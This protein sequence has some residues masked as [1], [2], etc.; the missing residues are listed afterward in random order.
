MALIDK[1]S[2]L[3]VPS[4]VAEGKAFNILPSGNR[5]PDNKG[6]AGYDQ[7]RADFDFDR[8]SNT[9][10]TRVNADGLIEKY[11]EN[12][13]LQ[14]NAF[15][16]TWASVGATETSGQ[17]GY[18]NTNNAWLIQ[19]TSSNGRIEQNTSYGSGVRTYSVYAKAGTSNILRIRMQGGANAYADFDLSDGSVDYT[20]SDVIESKINSV[21][22]GW[23]RCSI[24]TNDTSTKV[25][26]Y[27]I[28]A[29]GLNILI[30][31]TQLES[32]L[33]ATDVLTSGATTGKAGVL[34]DLP[35][36]NF[37]ANGENGSLLL[38]PSRT[39]LN[40]YSEYI[41]G[42]SDKIN[43]TLTPNAATSP[44][45]VDNA[46]KIY[47]TATGSAYFFDS[48]NLVS[49]TDY[50]YSIFV[51]QD[52]VRYYQLTTSGGATSGNNYANFDLQEGTK[53]FDSGFDDADIEDYGNG[54]YRIYVVFT[55]AATGIGRIIST[56][57]DEPTDGRL[58]AISK[59][60]TDGSL[61]YGSV[62]E[63]GSYPSSY[64]P[65][66]GESGGVTR[67]AD[68]CTGGGSAE[69]INSTEGVLYAEISALAEDVSF[70]TICLHDGTNTQRINIWYW[71]D[72]TF[73]VDGHNSNVQQ[74]NFDFDADLTATNKIA[75]KYKANDFSVFLN[76]SKMDSD[77][78]GATPIGLNT[79]D[80]RNGND[81]YPFYGNV[82]QLAVFNE[83]LSDS[84]LATLTT[85]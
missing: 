13:L 80:F 31:N 84:E 14:S 69:S 46:Y 17:S 29:S 25:Y 64:I 33:V 72:G 61:V 6:G 9:A 76:G 1:A 83:A 4:V 37:D 10:A 50:S 68:L 27:V 36:I 60:G 47:P 5:A 24:N 52:G 12:L 66:H 62:Y 44:E 42:W 74:F 15:D 23:Y 41:D 54:W 82:K 3:F 34:V 21:G 39:N 22:S 38:E 85:L 78:S 55:A 79:L 70:K 58:G 71:N 19:S 48:Q 77:T 67:A 35:R 32:G 59:N 65:N 73:K 49:G 81:L 40:A 26:I 2:L 16:T 51:K 43:V 57:I 28:G 20:D 8:G 30:Q 53:A 18:D 63:A 45:G 56:L 75:V 11:R 7:T